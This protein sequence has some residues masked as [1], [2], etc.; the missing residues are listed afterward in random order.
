M[1][2]L[3]TFIALLTSCLF[4]QAQ[5]NSYQKQ[6][7]TT[8]LP[9]ATV[10]NVS[11]QGSLAALPLQ[12]ATNLNSSVSWQWTNSLAG[13]LALQY[14][15]NG[16]AW[17]T[18]ETANSGGAFAFLGTTGFGQSGVGLGFDST[19]GGLHLN[20]GVGGN[21]VDANGQV[22]WPGGNFTF[23]QQ[24]GNLS[25]SAGNTIF[26]S[27]GDQFIGNGANGFALT[28]Q[29]IYTINVSNLNSSQFLYTNT[30]AIPAGPV[31]NTIAQAGTQP[32][33]QVYYQAANATGSATN[34]H[35]LIWGATGGTPDPAGYIG[36]VVSS[37]VLLS[38]PVSLTTGV[39]AN[40]TSI[41]LSA[42][43]WDVSGTITFQGVTAT[44][45]AVVAGISTT[46]ATLPANSNRAWLSVVTTVLSST[47]SIA[48]TD[49]QI[50]V[51]TT[52]TVYAVGVANFTA[53]TITE[54]GQLRARRIH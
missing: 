46:S 19:L 42:G 17:S 25:D 26:K 24:S 30:A 38:A 12:I 44:M 41:S 39:A 43:D 28:N 22:Y 54:F 2:I 37:A 48:L 15:A 50:N 51:P 53:G 4:A 13:I 23:L 7:F 18:Y 31:T 47:N 52:T 20:M 3:I 16:V 1:R 32:V 8:N 9:G 29:P 5:F 6:Q 36:E 35:M 14:T 21:V 10:L 33:M 40:M 34:A 11:L 27:T 49:T 45:S